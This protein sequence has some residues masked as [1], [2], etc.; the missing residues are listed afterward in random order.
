MKIKLSK[1]KW[2]S[3]VVLFSLFIVLFSAVEN[4]S[5]AGDKKPQKYKKNTTQTRKAHSNSVAP[6]P[7]FDDRVINPKKPIKPKKPGSVYQKPRK[8]KTMKKSTQPSKKRVMPKPRKKKA[9]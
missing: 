4:T 7:V 1:I 5:V 9:K 8:K 3:R 2:I 6:K